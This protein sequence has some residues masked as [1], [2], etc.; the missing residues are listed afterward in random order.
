MQS[1]WNMKTTLKNCSFI[2]LFLVFTGARVIAQTTK[3]FEVHE[4]QYGQAFAGSNQADTNAP[5]GYGQSSNLP[6]SN[7]AALDFAEGDLYLF[8]DTTS[9]FVFND[10][11]AA[12]A[13]YLVNQGDVTQSFGAADSRIHL[14][15]EVFVDNAWQPIER[16]P[17]I[18]CGN[19]YHQVNLDKDQYWVFHLPVYGGELAVKM[20]YRCALSSGIGQENEGQNFIYSNEFHGFIHAEQI[21]KPEEPKE[22]N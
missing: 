6:K 1:G 2:A 4:P 3:P 17:W 18:R 12:Y 11:Y 7:A 20:R 19:S 13:V 14:F 10:E 22:D 8:V 5:G 15:A 9:R 21:L 16:M